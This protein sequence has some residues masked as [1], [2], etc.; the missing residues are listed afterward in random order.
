VC[1]SLAK[2]KANGTRNSRENLSSP[3]QAKPGTLETG[4]ALLRNRKS[5]TSLDILLCFVDKDLDGGNKT[6]EVFQVLIKIE[7]IEYLGPVLFRFDES[8]VLEDFEMV[9]D[10]RPGKGGGSGD[11]CDI[12][13]LR[14][15]I[16]KVH[17]DLLS[18]IISKRYEN[19]GIEM[20]SF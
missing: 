15:C 13:S 1:H 19:R 20:E 3:A 17:D 16:G 9:G 5:F 7:K 12:D 6:R 8:A 18:C 4:K 14:P 11:G 2:D 10:G